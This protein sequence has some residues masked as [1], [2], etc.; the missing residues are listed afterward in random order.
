MELHHH[1]VAALVTDKK[2]DC[3]RLFSNEYLVPPSADGTPLKHPVGSK[4]EELRIGDKY[5]CAWPR[6]K[7]W[8]LLSFLQMVRVDN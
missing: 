3:F 4:S 8:K 5:R 6:L 2:L 1:K 7:H